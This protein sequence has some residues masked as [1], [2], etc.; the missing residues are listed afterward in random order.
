MRTSLHRR[1]AIVSSLVTMSLA[2]INPVVHPA[3]AQRGRA[4]IIASKPFGE[5]YVL[6]EMFAQLLER[7]GIAVDRRLGLG[8][9]EV[10]FGALQRDASC[11]QSQ[12]YY[13]L[14]VL[15]RCFVEVVLG[16]GEELFKLIYND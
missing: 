15:R 11:F 4:V 13:Y 2:L 8:A 3:G 5:S 1:W 12:V 16:V 9:T 6:A 7:R 14:R 10:A